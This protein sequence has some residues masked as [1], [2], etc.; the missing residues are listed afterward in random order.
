[1]GSKDCIHT[2][3]VV[4]RQRALKSEK[5]RA[6][7][8]FQ[9]YY[10]VFHIWL[11]N[12]QQNP[13]FFISFHDTVLGT[14]SW[15]EVLFPR[16]SRKMQATCYSFRARMPLSLHILCQNYSI[17]EYS[18]LLRVIFSYPS[19]SYVLPLRSY[20]TCGQQV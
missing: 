10:T 4:D 17:R 16:C 13:L 19:R 6:S 14:G 7:C 1:M 3:V 2:V 12:K 15:E 8:C 5:E 18:T 11:K 20:T 9:V